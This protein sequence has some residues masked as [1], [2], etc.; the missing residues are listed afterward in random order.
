M[1]VS[2]SGAVAVVAAIQL[3]VP[4]LAEAQMP[5][6]SRTALQRSDSGAILRVARGAQAK[7]ERIRFNNLPWAWE[8]GGREC[9]EIIGRFCITHG[10]SDDKWKP[11]PEPPRVTSERDALISALEAAALR[12]PGDNW[13]AGQRVRYLV[14]ADRHAE[15]LAAAGACRADQWWCTSLAALVEHRRGRFHE[16][17]SLF[18]VALAEM[19]EKESLR[20]SDLR[21]L[22]TGEDLRIFKR[23]TPERQDSLAS[24]LWWLAD[25]LWM[26]PGNDRR[27]EH[28]ARHVMDRIYKDARTPE[29]ASW[30]SDL[31][32]IL[33]RYGPMTGWERVRANTS[34]MGR[35]GV[36]GHFMPNGREFLPEARWFENPGAIVP[37]EWML[38][39]DGTKTE[40][41]PSYV[42]SFHSLE[43]Q[44][45]VFR[46]GDSALV[47][48]AFQ[49]PADSTPQSA[50]VE[51]ALVLASDERTTLATRRES[52]RGLRGVLNATVAAIP[53]VVSIEALV[54]SGKRAYRAR[55]G[56][57]MPGGGASSLSLSDVLLLEGAGGI[58][59]RSLE[60]AMIRARGTTAVKSGERVP[61][62]WE[63]YGLKAQEESLQ[64]EL[65]LE[66]VDHKWMRR[67]AERLRLRAP[68]PSVRLRWGDRSKGQDIVS[69]ALDLELPK[70]PRGRYVLRIIMRQG[71]EQA[72]AERRLVAR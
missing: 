19:P 58:K 3:V 18:E 41:L 13:V 21:I 11:P 1:L 36:V 53:A 52:S 40:Y 39:S 44:I 10:D 24:R 43:H 4:Y 59:A 63:V 5:Q 42:S 47:V 2:L 45:A 61:L 33:I 31:G 66:P 30:A 12:L 35:P 54:D 56:L 25:P 6:P 51:G 46:R 62:Y 38:K 9:D 14:E 49:L 48:A 32:E 17:D 28:Y 67:T 72:V 64:V 26:R 70:L 29:G 16:A 69:H 60:E 34:S 50:T 27:T 65:A 55:F 37:G 7:F 57:P 15:A 22:L 68:T 20:W 8:G 71:E 23:S